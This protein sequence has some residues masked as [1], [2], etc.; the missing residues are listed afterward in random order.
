V[1]EAFRYRGPDAREH[2]Y[3]GD[4]D[5]YFWLRQA[6]SYLRSGTVCDAVVDGECRDAHGG[7]PVGRLMPYDRS[8]HV[9]A[10]VALHRLVTVFSP[11]YPLDATAFWVP[12]L[13][14]GL[15][16]L[17]AFAIGAQL[18]G[19]MGGLVA[20]IVVGLDPMVLERTI[21]SDNDVWNVALPLLAVWAALG[22]ISASSR[23][24]R[25]AGAVLAG[26]FVGLHAA[27]WSGWVFTGV[28]VGVALLVL[29]GFAVVRAIVDRLRG[30]AIRAGRVRALVAALVMF[31]AVSGLA[32]AVAGAGGDLTS[33][34]A[35]VL[36]LVAPSPEVTGP[37]IWPATLETVGELVRPG[38]WGIGG[39]VGGNLRFFIAW[40]GLL[41]LVLPRRRWE[42]YHFAL[43]AT[44]N[45]LYYRLLVGETRD[46]GTLIGLMALPLA[47]ALAIAAVTN[48][49]G[50][51]DAAAVPVVVWFLAALYQ[52][53]EG[54]RFVLLLA[55]PLGIASG[56]AV[57]RL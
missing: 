47:L 31:A 29:L 13:V 41:A 54:Y 8:L 4:Y 40:L 25:A 1:E 24:R 17:P 18:A 48:R 36:H 34:P 52:A 45:V 14:G 46:A 10:I 38:L 51:R 56:A 5:S 19:P 37:G 57:G 32:A 3:L 44:G 43:L 12:V 7:A 6:R 39:S 2:V 11:A 9:A 49:L 55:P 21:G 23:S 42:W 26:T 30:S 28:I 33:L 22:S 20:A 53:L 27:V 15:A 35:R 16:V 50:R